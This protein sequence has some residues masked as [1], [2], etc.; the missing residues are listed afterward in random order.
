MQRSRSQTLRRSLSSGG[1]GTRDEGVVASTSKDSLDELA[2]EDK[3]DWTFPVP[4]SSTMGRTRSGSRV[5]SG[6]GNEGGRV[7]QRVQESDS[8]TPSLKGKEKEWV[9]KGKGKENGQTSY[10]SEAQQAREKE[11]RKE[12][13]RIRLVDSRITLSSLSTVD[14][15]RM[16]GSRRGSL[17]SIG[18]T[19]K[20][21]SHHAFYISPIESSTMHPSFPIESLPSPP[22]PSTRDDGV[23]VGIWVRPH[24]SQ[25]L[26]SDEGDWTLLLTYTVD[27]S[28]LVPFSNSVRT[29]FPSSLLV[30][31][32]RLDRP[33]NSHPFTVPIPSY[34]SCTTRTTPLLSHFHAAKIRKKRKRKKMSRITFQIRELGL[35][36]DGYRGNEEE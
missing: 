26:E 10:T 4:R 20:P 34:S 24:P 5:L 11:R 36:C 22:S 18:S 9:M 15:T 16:N 27:F 2:E 13:L 19:R 21:A 14:S 31:N 35:S 25:S 33:L 30:P 32:D 23:S 28:S 7:L 8:T 12:L 29:P 6:G 17:D 3:G 1:S